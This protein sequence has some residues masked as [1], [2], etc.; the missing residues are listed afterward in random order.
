MGEAPSVVVIG[1]PNGA[2]KTTI[3]RDYIGETLGIAEFVNA[4]V[5]A[6][7]LSGFE[8]EGAALQ[9]GRLMLMR[10]REL[11]AE[12]ATFAFETTMA[13]RSFAPWIA[14]LI[15]SG[16][17]F[18]AAFVW[19]R[20][21]ALAI[22]RVRARAA[23]G[24]HFVPPETVRRRYR[25]G[26]AN[27]VKLYMPIATRWKVYDNSGESGPVLVAHRAAGKPVLVIEPRAWG[28]VLEVAHEEADQDDR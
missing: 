10:L 19:V 7:G 18:E 16:Y 2:G 8:P 9:A 17:E 11:A 26:I 24:G 1:G 22:Q 13:S 15:G 20:S 28:R 4:D 21:P 25:R 6:Q 5:I 3:S 23:R 27:F 12:R 14:G